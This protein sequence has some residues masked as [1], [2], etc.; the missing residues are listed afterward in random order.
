MLFTITTQSVPLGTS[1]K[2]ASETP[3]G[4][5]YFPIITKKVSI[6]LQRRHPSNLQNTFSHVSF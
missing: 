4:L 1:P 5:L 3:Q 6:P 2:E